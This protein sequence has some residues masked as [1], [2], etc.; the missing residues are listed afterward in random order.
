MRDTHLTRS[1][2]PEALPPHR[3][4]QFLD[5]MQNQPDWR[6][7]ADREAAYYDGNQLTRQVVDELTERGMPPSVYNL[8]APTIDMVLG[9]EAKTRRD[10]V[11]TSDT[12]TSRRDLVAEALNVKLKEATRLSKF[13]R[14]TA[15]AYKGQVIT[16]LHWVYV[17]RAWDPFAYRYRVEPV[18]RREIWWDWHA[19]EADLSDA[20]YLTRKKW[21][22]QDVLEAIFPDQVDLIRAAVGQRA[23]WDLSWQTQAAFEVRD[24]LSTRYGW[25]WDD[26]E[27]FDTGRR[28]ACLYEVWY[29][30]F[31]RGHVIRLRDDRVIEFHERN[32]VH[33]AA[34]RA[35]AGEIEEA[36]FPHVRLSWWLGPFP[37]HDLP[38]PYPHARFPYV[39]FWGKRED[40][41]GAPYGLTRSMMYPQDEINAR[42]SKML[43]QLNAKRVIGDHDAVLDQDWDTLTREV[44]RP[45]AVIKLNPARL[46][47]T[48]DALRV[49][50]DPAL[51]G[52]QMEMFNL[53]REMIQA[54]PGVYNEM[55]GRGRT[56]QSGVAIAELVEQGQ[57]TLADI[58]DNYYDSRQ[59]AG[60]I[61]LDLIKEDLSKQDNVDVVVTRG[62]RK[63]LVVLNQVR[64]DQGGIQ[65]RDNDVITNRARVALSEVPATA[66]YRQQVFSQ[67]VELV[68]GLPPDIQG[69][70]V[71]LVVEASDLPNKDDVVARIRTMTGV[72]D[73]SPDDMTP[74]EQV[75]AQA[76]A[77]EQE[78][79]RQ[80]EQAQLAREAQAADLQIAHTEQD[81]RIKAEEHT[82][83]LAQE[84]MNA[85]L[86]RA[87]FELQRWESMHKASL[88]RLQTDSR[89]KLE[90][91]KLAVQASGSQAA[92]QARTAA[93]RAALTAQAAADARA[94][95]EARLAAEQARIA[96]EEAQRALEMRLE[97]E[98][99]AREAAER[100]PAEPEEAEESEPEVPALTPE[101]LV[102]VVVQAVRAAAPRK[103]PVTKH[104]TLVR[105][106]DGRLEGADVVETPA[107]GEGVP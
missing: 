52:Q 24:T 66:T 38:T 86:D 82:A 20:R 7:T 94:V 53:A 90:S 36:V 72:D 84:R 71:D 98:S 107:P 21:Y 57:T 34:L 6:S 87:R 96:A 101:V 26:F 97:Q 95:E 60:E 93:E 59:I 32:P 50:T 99:A 47:R 75:A 27:W 68:K 100:E 16:G 43:W 55:L 23:D 31:K 45:D 8:I 63:Q 54:S 11:L 22:D 2:S 64:T 4:A 105:G 25:T 5:D 76:R 49:E 80:L 44:S 88:E 29:R 56:G 58:N 67:L 69:M 70:L 14:A 46:N 104:I 103:T 1:V 9:L 3:L 33:A 15:E 18:S 83:K 40:A 28:R 30:S 92:I 61:L 89:A 73:P 19:K 48:P 78:Q 106:A 74:E 91:E 85:A 65:V 35:G 41:T 81:L 17:G 39:P 42:A 62:H 12:P 79:A 37:L 77:A 51:S 102:D 10:L 13:N